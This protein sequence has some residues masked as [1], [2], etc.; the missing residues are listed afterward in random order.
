MKVWPGTH[1]PDSVMVIAGVLA[2]CAVILGII[3]V[4]AMVLIYLERKIAGH[5]QSRL[6]PMRVGWHGILQSVADGLKLLVKEDVIP[7]HANRFLFSFAPA[8]VFVGALVPFA[9]LPFADRIVV[10]NMDLGLYFILA[11]LSLEVVGVIMAGWASNSKWSLY[12]GMRLAA[13]MMSYEIPLGMSVM[14]VVLLA[15]SLNMSQIAAGQA[16]V[17]YVL[18]SPW[19]FV[20]FVIFYVAALASAKRAPFDLPEAESELVS[21]FHTEY[22]GMRFSFFFLA[23]YAAMVLLSGVGAVVFLGGWNF[24][25]PGEGRPLLGL[26]QF[27]AKTSVLLFVMLWLRWTLPRIRVDQ[28]MYL[29]LK[30]LLPF[31][32]VCV[33]GAAVEV[34][35]GAHLTMWGVFVVLAGVSFLLARK[36]KSYSER[37]VRQIPAA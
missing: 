29:C 11:F 31:G 18:M 7:D 33:L 17:P 34:V 21:G 6:G 24:P 35:T 20:A 32:M 19:G 9:A 30:V 10:A 23:E 1:I 26:V 4:A 14:T 2:A 25:F 3:S 36:S 8:L 5:I 37:S 22:S 15:G 12:G 16:V 27:T 13:Q 28:V